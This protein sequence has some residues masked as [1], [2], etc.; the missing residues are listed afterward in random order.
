[1]TLSEESMLTLSPEIALP[2]A[3][4]PRISARLA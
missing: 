4:V 2:A 1:M 3:S